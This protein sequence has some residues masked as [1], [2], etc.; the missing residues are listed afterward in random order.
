MSP[1]GVG[2]ARRG[3]DSMA[4]RAANL[5]LAIGAFFL[6]LSFGAVPA[7]AASPETR[8]VNDSR[9][10][11]RC[12]SGETR[13]RRA[14]SWISATGS[15]FAPSRWPI[16]TASSSTCRRSPSSCRPRPGETGARPH[17][18]VPL[19]AG[20]A[21]RF[22]HRDRPRPGRRASKRRSCSTLPTAS[23]RVSC[24]TSRRSTAIAS[25][26]RS[27]STTAPRCAQAA[28]RKPSWPRRTATRAR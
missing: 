2:Q 21:G 24:S 15:T 25:C 3:S 14:S 27:R 23:P 1:H 26:A 6:S 12:G 9:S 18:G 20:D 4:I 28:G 11:P 7:R 5:G 10:P 19:R 17:Q 22:A 8:A 13:R 16:P